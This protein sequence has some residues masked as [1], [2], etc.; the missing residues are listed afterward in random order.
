MIHRFG[1]YLFLI[2]GSAPAIWG[3]SRDQ[4][5][6]ELQRSIARR[7]AIPVYAVR[8]RPIH[9]SRHLLQAE[10]ISVN[11]NRIRLRTGIQS[12]PC[13]RSIDNKLGYMTADV[14]IKLP[15]LVTT[16]PLHRGDTLKADMYQL[17]QIELNQAPD[18][19]F[20]D[21]IELKGK[22]AAKYIPSGKPIT[23]GSVMLPPLV[24]A[25]KPVTLTI[26]RKSLTLR[27]PAVALQTGKAG[28]MVRVRIPQTGRLQ[29]AVVTGPAQVEL[30]TGRN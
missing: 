20:R 16:R 24:T 26:R 23:R 22:V 18:E 9:I 1:K 25:G 19:Y 14:Q 21:P 13:R 11:L 3:L 28:E 30:G 5:A 10:A 27:L 7:Y 29:T 6:Q 8:V 2:L 15:V 4:L 12:F 17:K